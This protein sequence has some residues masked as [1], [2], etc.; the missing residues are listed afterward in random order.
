VLQ[1]IIGNIRKIVASGRRELRRGKNATL[2]G[3]RLAYSASA[4]EYAELG[5]GLAFQAVRLHTGK[6]SESPILK[7][8]TH[9][10]Q[11][12]AER[13]IIVRSLSALATLSIAAGMACCDLSS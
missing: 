1:S 4:A 9:E 8:D 2:K 12:E 5:M 13:L 10:A 7:T 3:D 6:V 11:L